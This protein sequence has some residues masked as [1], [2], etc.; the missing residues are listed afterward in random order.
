MQS[1]NDLS[2]LP[3][4]SLYAERNATNREF[5]VVCGCAAAVLVGTERLAPMCAEPVG[6]VS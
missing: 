5:A 2:G 4:D 3:G 1:C 6:L